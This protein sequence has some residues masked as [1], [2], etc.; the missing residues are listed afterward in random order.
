MAEIARI[1]E[2]LLF[3]ADAPLTRAQIAEA[4]PE[5]T[6]EELEGALGE[7]A[8]FYDDSGR[9]FCLAAVGGGHQLLTRPALSPWVERLLVGRRRQRLSRAGLEVLAVIAY[10]QPVTR[11]E[12][13]TVRGVDCGASLRTLLERKLIAVRGRA[14][15]AGHPLL[16]AT[17]DRFLEH[18]GIADISE[19]PKLEEFAALVDREAARAEVREAGQG[20]ATAG[21]AD[22]QGEAAQGRAA[23]PELAE[24]EGPGEPLGA[25]EAD[26]DAPAEPAAPGSADAAA[27]AEPADAGAFV[28]SGGGPAGAGS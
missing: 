4:I 22:A 6:V 26:A 17:T 9:G 8:R 14:R 23:A 3:A 28:R 7:L 18:F 20:E 11:G 19:L 1:V 21:P 16:Y 12:I 13:E 5:A 25:A 10:R 27:L 2:A 15:A 24:D